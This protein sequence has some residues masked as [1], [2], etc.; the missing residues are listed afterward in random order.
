MDSKGTVCV[1]GAA[2]Y[3]GSWLVMRLLERGYTVKA[4]VRD[5]NKEEKVKHLVDLPGSKTRLSLWKADL[6]DEG[7]F[8]EAIDGCIAVFHNATPMDFLSK[9]PENEVI[10]PTVD[11][12][13][14][15]MRSCL[16]AKS[17]QKIVFTSSAG[18]VTMQEHL[19]PVYDE[20]CWTDV[21]FCRKKKM[22][23]WMY[24]VSKTLAEKAA[25]EFAEQNGLNLV[26]V[27]P[28]LVNGQ[29]I[30]NS[31]PPSMLTALALITK[32]VP[33]YSILN[34]IQFVHLDDLCHALIFLFEHPEA[35]GRYICSS[36]DITLPDLAKMLRDI[37][38]EYDIPTEFE[39]IDK[40]H[41]LVR[42]S[43][44]KLLDLGFEYKYSLEDMY[45]GAIHTCRAK[46][47]IPLATK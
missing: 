37:Y 9:D 36:H 8:D 12:V 47:L 17:L 46:R 31:M 7:S 13:L 39:G 25:I 10:K 16:K 26:S 4:T 15:I 21:D 38:P 5:P 3:V 6:V 45:K 44:K 14:N 20:D 40:I 19:K 22:T 24:F 35:K 2:G 32:N 23:A 29:F 42:F 11:G 18:A 28:T 33:H 27:I 30:M 1:T 41:D 34:P 43:S